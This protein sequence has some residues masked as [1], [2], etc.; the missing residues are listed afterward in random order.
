MSLEL[1]PMNAFAYIELGVAYEGVGDYA[2]SLEA[3]EEMDM[4]LDRLK[5]YPT[6]NERGI[7]VYINVFLNNTKHAMY[8]ERTDSLLD[9]NN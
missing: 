3:V 9:P 2:G 6:T 1:D 8:E 4:V 7:S 5:Y